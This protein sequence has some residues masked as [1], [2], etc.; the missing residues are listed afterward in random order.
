MRAIAIKLGLFALVTTSMTVALASVIGNFGLLSP[1]YEVFAQ[2]EDATGLLKGDLVT[3]AGVEIGKVKGAAVERGYA[4]VTLQVDDAVRIPDDSRVQIRYRNLIGQRVVLIQPGESSSM[5]EPGDVVPFTRTVGP[6]DLNRVFNNLRPLLATVE[7]G[8]VDTISE[9]LVTSFGAHKD[10]L[11]A[12]LRD[13]SSV[14]QELAKKDEKI[15]SLIANVDTVATELAD[16]REELEG[17]LEDFA[18][19][20]GVL[21]DRTG[22]ID[23]TLVNLDRATGDFG[24]LIAGNR[25]GL[26]QDLKD[27]AT[28]LALVVEH[29][30][31]LDT[32]TSQLDDVLRATARGTTYGE[33]GSLYVFSLCSK[34]TAGC[35]AP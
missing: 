23:R 15:A 27:V 19:F 25:A 7:A 34:G 18:S 9:A 10:D 2:F 12:V 32:I 6:L 30:Q 20:T 26:D 24:R 16:Q 11:D 33:W 3:L 8:D 35:E 29:Q 4:R 14:T 1:R 17:L 31:D 28:L 5:L 13:A 21:S 22:P